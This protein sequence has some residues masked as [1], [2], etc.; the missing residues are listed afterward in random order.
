MGEGYEKPSYTTKDA[1]SMEDTIY[2]LDIDCIEAERVRGW[3]EVRVA[4]RG[5][6][7][8]YTGTRDRDYFSALAKSLDAAMKATH[9]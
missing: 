2:H 4:V 6:E 8:A 9:Y 3:W 7:D 5:S 1:R